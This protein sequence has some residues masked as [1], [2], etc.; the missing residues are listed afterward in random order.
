MDLAR[1]VSLWVDSRLVSL[2]EYPH[3]IC[4]L[5]KTP[6]LVPPCIQD[7]MELIAKKWGFQ[8][9]GIVAKAREL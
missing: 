6:R 2:V 3:G 1:R 7:A 9:R 5:I 8:D 4:G